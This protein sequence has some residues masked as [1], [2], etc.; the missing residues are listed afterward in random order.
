MW[1]NEISSIVFTRIKTEATKR[2][3]GKYPD[4]YFTNSD[5][6]QTE[7]KFPTVYIHE[8]GSVEQGQDLENLQINAVMTTFQIDVTD[9][10]SQNRANNVM[11]CVVEIMKSMR[12]S[13]VSMPEFQNTESTY[14]SI[15]RFRR[16]IGSGDI[17]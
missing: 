6:A 1:T 13:V 11:S 3:S 15:A 4:I 10:Q 5:R 17:L 2:L 8:I 7:P 16:V 9:N 12:F 14:R